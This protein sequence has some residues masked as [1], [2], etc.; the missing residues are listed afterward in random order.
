MARYR[1]RRQK[2]A[3]MSEMNVVPYIDVMLVLLVIFMITA[4]LLSTG[5]EVDLPNTNAKPVQSDNQSEALILSVSSIGEWYLKIGEE[6]QQLVEQTEA[7]KIAAD[8]L[9]ADP[10][11]PVMVA[12]DENINY[13]TV[14]EAM[15][16]LQGA[17]AAQVQLMSD[18]PQ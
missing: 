2:K 16:T 6:P 8:A 14:M 10:S 1:E 12:A 13:G 18:P 3:L 11:R 17:G 4:P 7:L 9:R 5:V 15:A